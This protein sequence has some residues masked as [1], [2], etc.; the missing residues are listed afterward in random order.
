M[1][2]F[3][4]LRQFFIDSYDDFKQHKNLFIKAFSVLV[5][6]N[7]FEAFP[8]EIMGLG[9]NSGPE[10][11]SNVM[12]GVIGLIVM[13]DVINAQ[14]AIVR[15]QN[16]E[17]LL[18]TVPSF[19]ISQIIYLIISLIGLALFIV[20]GLLAFIFFG[21]A[22]LLTIVE[23]NASAFKRSFALTK[24]DFVTVAVLI[25]GSLLIELI[26]AGVA[27]LPGWQLRSIVLIVLS[28]PLALL[29]FVLIQ[30][31]VKLYYH[32]INGV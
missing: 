25:I 32:L 19:F 30:S 3:P 9:Q 5:V 4:L 1:N 27:L 8:W 12:I 10:L 18:Y 31:T 14:V 21:L 23:P 22:P 29:A 2:S 13:V 11:I 20:P 15:N 7:I 24:K 17:R 28:Y 16:K 26:P 6:L